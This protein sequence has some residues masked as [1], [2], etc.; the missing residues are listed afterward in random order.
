MQTLLQGLCGANNE[1]CEYFS[2]QFLLCHFETQKNQEEKCAKFLARAKN[3]PGCLRMG[4]EEP[5]R[6]TENAS[7]RMRI[8]SRE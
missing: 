4:K 6:L 3:D 1:K 2:R 5:T 8:F 7:E